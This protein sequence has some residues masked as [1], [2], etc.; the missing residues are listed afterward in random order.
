ME[1]LISVIVPVYNVERYLPHC[2]ESILSQTYQNLEVI[3][4]D[5]GST[6]RSGDI[7]DDFGKKDPR[8]KVIHKAN[9]GQSSARNR[10]LDICR[11]EYIGFVDSDDFISPHY[12]ELLYNGLQR[13]GSDI[14][15]IDRILYFSDESEENVKFT[16]NIG[17]CAMEPIEPREAIRRMM[18]QRI[19]TGFVWRLYR[20]EI[21][22]DLRMPEGW[23]Y[24]DAAATHRAFM[25]A[26]KM[27]MVHG[28]IYAYRVRPDS[29]MHMA[30]NQKKMIAVKVSEQIVDD[31]RAYDPALLAAANSRAF[32]VSYNVFTQVPFGDRKDMKK[33]WKGMLLYRNVAAH[34]RDPY[35]RKKVHAAAWLTYLGMDVNSV[36]GRVY[37]RIS[38][39]QLARRCKRP[40]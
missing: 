1:P 15:T 28:Y 37:R 25:K 31:A 13:F 22:Q 39:R 19:P 5:D 35:Q 9:G 34:D 2:V 21:F 32:S 40:E 33:L 10:G 12:Y 3:L 18:Y 23:I 17:D 30:F 29:T 11:G 7:C 27:T 36:A 4:V 24:E 6:D 8:V 20:R 38:D 26:K 16:E 14:A